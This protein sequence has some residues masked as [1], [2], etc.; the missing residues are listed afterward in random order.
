[1][2]SDVAVDDGDEIAERLDK[3]EPCWKISGEYVSAT[4]DVITHRIFQAFVSFSE[5]RPGGKVGFA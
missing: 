1:M 4:G 5:G 2:K 3:E